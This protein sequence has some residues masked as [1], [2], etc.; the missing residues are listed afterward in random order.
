MKAISGKKLVSVLRKN[1]WKLDRINGSHYILTKPGN[2]KAIVV[3]V[4]GNRALKIGLR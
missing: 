1:G 4:H 2:E 3:P